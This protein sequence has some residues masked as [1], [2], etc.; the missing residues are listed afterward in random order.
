MSNKET[1]TTVPRKKVRIILPYL[2]YTSVFIK[3]RLK[4]V[5]NNIPCC[6]L[7]VIFKTTYRMGNLFRY[8]DNF[9]DSIISD[10]VY[11]FKCGSCPA[12]CVGR[13]LRHKKVRFSE[14][15]GISP[16][17]GNKL[18]LTKINASAIKCH[19]IDNGHDVNVGDFSILSKGGNTL[20]LDIKESIMIHK[21]KPSL[22]NNIKS[23]ELYLYA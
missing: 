3:K 4:H 9:P 8:K 20:S 6:Q 7:E 2:G 14:H 15:S 13:C 17:T 11:H 21:L 10:L 18:Q 1:V 23:T 5:F 22:N 12:S 19:M 16:R